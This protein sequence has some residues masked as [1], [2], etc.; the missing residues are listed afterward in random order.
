[1][2][3]RLAFDVWPMVSLLHERADDE[4]DRRVLCRSLVDGLWMRIPV[5]MHGPEDEGLEDDPRCDG[6]ILE[7][8]DAPATDSVLEIAGE[9]REGAVPAGAIPELREVR[10]VEGTAVEELDPGAVTGERVVE[11]AQHV[12]ELR[13]DVRD[14]RARER[15]AQSGQGPVVSE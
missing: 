10:V 15:G 2:S 4:P 9:E 12:L 14:A 13:A 5:P 7:R 6:R 11:L 3:Y 1:M 8:A